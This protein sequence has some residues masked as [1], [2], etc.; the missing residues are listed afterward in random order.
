MSPLNVAAPQPI[1]ASNDCRCAEADARS[2]PASPLRVLVA[3]ASYG[4]G[5]EVFLERLFQEYRSMSFDV[6]IVVLSNVNKALPDDAE[7]I[8]GLPTR[9]PWSL[10]FLHKQLF[11]DRVDNYELFIYTED[12]T[13][14]TEDHLQAF[15]AVDPELREDE[16]AGFLRFEVSPE[17][18]VSYPD[19]HGHFHWDVTSI[20]TRGPYTLAHFTNEHAACY[21][22]PQRKLR[23]A[24]ASGG[25][26]VRP[27][28]WKYDLLC[29]AATDPYTQCGF[30]KLIPVSHLE[31][32]MVHHL[33]N[34]YAGRLGLDK[35]SL[36]RQISTIL[37]AGSQRSSPSPLIKSETRLRYGVYSKSYY[38]PASEAVVAAIPRS[39]RA[40]LSI[41]CGSGELERALLSHGLRVVAV[42]L[43][44]VIS[45]DARASGVQIV[46]SD[47]K[48][49]HEELCAERFDCILYSNI[50]HLTD[51]PA[52]VLSS[53][54][55][56]L[57]ENGTVIIQL[58]NM[59]FWRSIWKAVR[60]REGLIVRRGYWRT[61]AHL[62]CLSA[63]R[64][65]CRRSG[66]AVLRTHAVAGGRTLNSRIGSQLANLFLAHE[67][68]VVARPPAPR[69]RRKHDKLG[70]P[71]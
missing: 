27:H 42:P 32:F 37:K 31:Q 40:V 52:A 70:R 57:S 2:S 8:V 25:F 64:R 36:G 24:L 4:I 41:G 20:R 22:L 48:T 5:N 68:V 1:L 14:I 15:L 66:L 33:P 30:R 6:D 47:F 9:D 18:L 63:A 65:W 60:K 26:L 3:I 58:V 21:V 19:M 43:D 13:L 11:A 34:K 54:A 56:L 39:A 12:D 44:C 17:G 62:S 38:E 53:F 67:L 29:T 16:I 28:Q 61:R 45:A 35:A 10:P 49:A 50:L 59:L 51:D 23:A 7:I 55:G 69:S 71:T 46:T